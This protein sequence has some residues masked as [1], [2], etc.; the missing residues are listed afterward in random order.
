MIFQVYQLVPLSSR[1]KG[2]IGL[3]QREE[4]KLY[5]VRLHGEVGNTENGLSSPTAL[6]EPEI[7]FRMC[8]LS[9]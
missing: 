7:S 1:N 8:S 6:C 9:N 3:L 4:K 2:S 5:S